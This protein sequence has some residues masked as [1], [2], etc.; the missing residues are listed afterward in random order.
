M[1]SPKP[2]KKHEKVVVV[3]G[4]SLEDALGEG[5][6]HSYSEEEKVV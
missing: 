2:R 6:T 5:S 1:A 4:L 3:G